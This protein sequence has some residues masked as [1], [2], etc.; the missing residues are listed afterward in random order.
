MIVKECS[1]I[2]QWL[3]RKGLRSLWD[4]GLS[5]S[6]DL[7]GGRVMRLHDGLSFNGKRKDSGLEFRYA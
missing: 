7:R 6:F 5:A 4:V 3:L 2:A 1:S